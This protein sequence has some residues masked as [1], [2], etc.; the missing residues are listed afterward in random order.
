MSD[1]QFA[2]AS[3]QPVALVIEDDEDV[4]DLLQVILTQAGFSVLAAT[5]GAQG[6]ALAREHHPVLATIDVAMPEMDGLEATR[7]IREFSNTY[8]VIISTRSLEQDILAGFDA[9]ADDY[10]P[11][12]IKPK[13]LRARLAAVA[14]RPPAG[15]PYAESL[16]ADWAP[17]EAD[18]ARSEQLRRVAAGEPVAD[19]VSDSD[20]D[21]GP[22]EGVAGRD[23]MLEIGMRFVGGWIEFRGLRINPARGIVVVDDRLVD[24]PTEQVDLMETLMYFGT[25]TATARQ[26]ALRMRNL[27][28]ATAT[29]N[30]QQDIAWIEALMTGLRTA[31]GE[32][33]EQPRWIEELSGPRY[34]LVRSNPSGSG[35]DPA[36]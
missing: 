4:S 20:A 10:V 11:K 32:S 2:P 36:A 29:T 28:E 24:M 22:D 15:T 30:R 26:L 14:K 3:E 5:N 16:M 6:I 9:G 27:T 1:P 19:G 31:I 34:R 12:P 8:I 21:G 25:R 18:P 23:G 33:R 17:A 35:D 7:R 13:E